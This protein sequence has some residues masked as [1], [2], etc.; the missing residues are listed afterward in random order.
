[1]FFRKIISIKILCQEKNI[2]L[3]NLL[4]FI[5]FRIRRR[6]RGYYI[7]L[8]GCDAMDIQWRDK[9]ELR[10]LR[11]Q[12]IELYGDLKPYPPSTRSGISQAQYPIVFL[13]DL[14]LS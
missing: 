9:F 12:Y 4:Q 8:D 7:M 13:Q 1:M 3:E 11:N 10:L 14:I 2:L 5:F 6:L